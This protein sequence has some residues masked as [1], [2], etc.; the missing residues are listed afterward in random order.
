MYVDVRRCPL[1]SEAVGRRACEKLTALVAG[2]HP[3]SPSRPAAGWDRRGSARPGRQRRRRASS[4]WHRASTAGRV[5]RRFPVRDSAGRSV[6]LVPG[7]G[8]DSAGD[9]SSAW[10]ST[11]SDAG[12]R[13]S[14]P[15]PGLPQ[16]H[17]DWSLGSNPRLD[18]GVQRVPASDGPGHGGRGRQLRDLAG[19]AMLALRP[20]ARRWR[21][22]LKDLEHPPA[23]RDHLLLR[24]VDRSPRVSRRRP[25]ASS[26]SSSVPAIT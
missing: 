20:R 2:P 4:W 21:T 23:P 18:V 14:R 26:R 16:C 9:R 5:A 1:M 7:S 25:K 19:C 10:S 15:Q 11:A 13:G 3:A 22:T 17:R 12:G 8:L 24:A 6:P